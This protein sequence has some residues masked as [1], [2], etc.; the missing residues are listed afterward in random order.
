MQNHQRRIVAA[1]EKIEAGTYI[2]AKKGEADFFKKGDRGVCLGKYYGSN[3]RVPHYVF[4]F[5]NGCYTDLSRGEA[6][7]F[8]TYQSPGSSKL[9]NYQFKHL[10]QIADDVA[11]GVFKDVW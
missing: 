10:T 3:N 9:E 6:N 4:V 8:F 1:S 2:I 11:K 5:E 7:K